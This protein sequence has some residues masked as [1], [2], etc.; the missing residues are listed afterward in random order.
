MRFHISISVIIH[1]QTLTGWKFYE[2]RKHQPRAYY[3]STPRESSIEK[4][5]TNCFPKPPKSQ[6]ADCHDKYKQDGDVTD[7]CGKQDSIRS[8][9][10]SKSPRNVVRQRFLTNMVQAPMPMLISQGKP[11]PHRLS[12]NRTKLRK[13]A[14]G[15]DSGHRSRPTWRTWRCVERL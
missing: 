2:Q 9:Q 14:P 10:K 13:S 8:H 1:H 5:Y 15:S 7:Y 4:D 11:I 12:Q 3:L 6:T